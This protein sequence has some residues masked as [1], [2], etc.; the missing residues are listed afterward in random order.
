[1]AVVTSIDNA[2]VKA[3]RK[4]ARRQARERTGAFLVEGPQ[5]VGEALAHLRQLFAAPQ[6]DGALVA[7]AQVRGVPVVAVSDRVL[8]SLADTVAP[9]GLVGVAELAVPALDA[10]LTDARLV[11][12]CWQIRD[13]GN[14]G[15]LVRSADA[16]G[17]DAVVCTTGSVDVRNPKAVRASAGSLF[18]LPVVPAA[19]ASD[20]IAAC[21]TRGLQIVAADAAG[22]TAYTAVDLARPTALLLGNEAHGLPAELLDTADVVAAVPIHGRAESLNLSATAAVLVYEAARQ[23]AERVCG[24]PVRA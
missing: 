2:A 13:P 17:A 10:V 20:V 3:A 16:A 5:A 21:R 12:V 19:D 1:M 18:H 7:A 11:V 22:A 4:L 24:A 15:T 6:A 8:A 14:A 23:R 9:Q